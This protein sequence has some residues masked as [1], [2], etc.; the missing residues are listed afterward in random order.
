MR[1]PVPGIR[2]TNTEDEITDF[3][4]Q[5]ADW[6]DGKHSGKNCGA[7]RST[8]QSLRRGGEWFESISSR[9]RTILLDCQKYSTTV[10][11]RSNH[12]YS[13]NKICATSWNG[14]YPS[15]VFA[16]DLIS[17]IFNTNGGVRWQFSISFGCSILQDKTRTTKLGPN[18]KKD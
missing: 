14:F 3:I 17:K 5:I 6:D 18:L 12:I 1:P 4:A 15:N 13:K 2:G 16:P 11:E 10:N 8:N 9:L 7:L